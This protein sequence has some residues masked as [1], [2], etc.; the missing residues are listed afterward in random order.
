MKQSIQ[1]QNST[2]YSLVAQKNLVSGIGN[3]F[4]YAQL[5]SAKNVLGYA[6]IIIYCF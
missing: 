6:N 2:T 4:P 1:I 5:P 3:N